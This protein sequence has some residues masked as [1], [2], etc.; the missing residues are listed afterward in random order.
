MHIHI[1][2]SFIILVPNLLEKV[3]EQVAHAGGV[4]DVGAVVGIGD[5]ECLATGDIVANQAG[6]LGAYE[7]TI[8]RHNQCRTPDT[9]H[10]LHCHRRLVHHHN[11][12]WV[13]VLLRKKSCL[14]FG[15][16]G[17]THKYVGTSRSDSTQSAGVH[18]LRH[19]SHDATIAETKDRRLFQ[20]LG[21][22][23]L[24]QVGSHIVVVVLG[25]WRVGTLTARVESVDHVSRL[26]QL[27]RGGLHIVVAAAVAVEQ[28]DGFALALGSV[29]ECHI[30]R[31][32]GVGITNITL[33]T[34]RSKSR[35][36]K[37]QKS[38][39]PVPAANRTTLPSLR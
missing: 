14:K 22:D 11:I 16:Q 39:L 26:C 7:V 12:Q 31:I 33:A 24:V 6:V 13:G 3:Q 5:D 28:D 35:G 27:A 20:S 37:E 10:I 36:R 8:A 19:Q 2:L 17:T 34:A 38:G 21:G 4:V 32:E 1:S 23:E 18:N 25:E 9:L 29:E 30:A 15:H